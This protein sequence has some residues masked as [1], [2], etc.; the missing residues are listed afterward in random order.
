MARPKTDV[1]DD[2]ATAARI[3]ADLERAERL[4]ATEADNY[5]RTH[6]PQHDEQAAE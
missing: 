6:A 4:A 1:A 3:K 5:A 2:E